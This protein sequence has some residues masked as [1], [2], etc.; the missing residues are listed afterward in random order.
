MD[1][2]L[3]IFVMIMGRMRQLLSESAE[4]GK[5]VV[6]SKK[7]DNCIQNADDVGG[8]CEND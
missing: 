7:R 2:S 6:E 1:K 8:D 5:A 4:F 3:S